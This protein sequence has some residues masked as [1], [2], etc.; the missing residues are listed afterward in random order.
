[1][2]RE[3]EK[4]R[5]VGVPPS[6]VEDPASVVLVQQGW[7]SGRRG[8][9]QQERW[10]AEALAEERWRE[11]SD[12]SGRSAEKIRGSLTWSDF[13]QANGTVRPPCNLLLGGSAARHL[14]DSSSSARPSRL[15]GRFRSRSQALHYGIYLVWSS[16]QSDSFTQFNDAQYNARSNQIAEFIGLSA[17]L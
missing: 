4:R 15:S 16:R 7:R 3:R 9:A 6:T 8:S 17:P 1:M 13:P 12:R 14:A 2:K 11:L 5:R 10:P